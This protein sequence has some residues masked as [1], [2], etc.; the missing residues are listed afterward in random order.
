ML[1]LAPIS[2]IAMFDAHVISVHV[3]KIAP[4]GPDNVPSAIVKRAVEGPVIVSTLGLAGDEQADRRVHGG[5]DMAVYGYGSRHYVAWAAEY[6]EH[7]AQFAPGGVGEN[8]AIDGIVEEDIC[9]GDVHAIG[10]ALLQVCQPRQ[11]CFK[12]ALKFGDNKLPRA[13]VRSGRSG[14]YYRVAQ[15]GEIAP[16]D[17]VSL[18]ARPNPDFAFP[19]LVEIVNHGAVTWEELRRLAAMEGLAKKLRVMAAQSLSASE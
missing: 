9:V 16:G 5:L 15:T 4:L 2:E 7:A 12:F 18:R 14:W 1:G 6:P 13:M 3:G 10:S 8:L 19:R 17:R 11:P